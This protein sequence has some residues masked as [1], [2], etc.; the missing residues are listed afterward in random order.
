[1]KTQVRRG[2]F[3]TNS[4]ST[5]SLTICTEEQFEEWKHGEVLFIEWEKQG[6]DFVPAFV[7]TDR[8]KKEAASNYE[9]CKDE[10]QK[11]FD[12]LS[13]TAKEKIYRK[14]AKENNLVN[15]DAQTY[16]QYM[17][18]DYLESY[19]RHYT[20]KHGDRIVIFGRYGCEY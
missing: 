19:E 17:N 1:M 3:E 7:L 10:F 16:D 15:E 12:D 20:T 18:D 14:Y 13:D 4:S 2:V 6:Q 5:H 11:D 8:D 9:A